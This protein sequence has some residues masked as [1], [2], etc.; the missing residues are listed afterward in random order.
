[1]KVVVLGWSFSGGSDEFS[2]SMMNK[3]MKRERERELW[4][5]SSRNFTRDSETLRAV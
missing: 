4:L 3:K 2:D 5:A 1:M